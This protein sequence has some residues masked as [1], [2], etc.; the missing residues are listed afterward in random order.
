M[1]NLKKYISNYPDTQQVKNHFYKYGLL[2]NRTDNDIRFHKFSPLSK[3]FV[4]FTNARDESNLIEWCSYHLSLGFDCIYIFD[5]IS[6]EPIQILNEKVCV[7]RINPKKHVKY[8]CIQ[9]AL[10]I[11][12]IIHCEWMLYLDADEYLVLNSSNCVQSFIESYPSDAKLISLNWLM[13]GTNNFITQPHGYLIE[14]FTKSDRFLNKHVKTFV[15]PECVKELFTPHTYNIHGNGYNC[16]RERIESSPFVE[17]NDSFENVSGY[18]AH[19]IYQSEEVY[20][21]RKINKPSDLGSQRPLDKTI[22]MQFNEIDNISLKLKVKQI[23][24]YLKEHSF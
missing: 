13:F 14:N 18:I 9:Q 21:K 10:K 5:H 4:L 7:F 11:A 2:E 16:K 1:F 12:K 23:E 15:K 3:K 24:N 19:Y 6:Q 22:H 17:I 20:L 8:N